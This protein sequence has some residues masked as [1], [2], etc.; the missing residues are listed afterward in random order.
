MPGTTR[1][2]YLN[3]TAVWKGVGL[4]R[5]T[6]VQ[7]QALFALGVVGHLTETFLDSSYYL[8]LSSGVESVARLKPLHQ[9]T[10][11]RQDKTK[12][13]EMVYAH[14]PQQQ[15]K[16]ICYVSTTDINAR[17]RMWQ[18]KTCTST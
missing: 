13:G 17:D 15:H 9:T 2:D 6:P 4:Q 14:L 3:N 10:D 5:M 16:V 18:C 8:A 12:G 11:N 7:F 1:G